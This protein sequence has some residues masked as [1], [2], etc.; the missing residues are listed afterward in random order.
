MPI[1]CCCPGMAFQT[2]VPI[3]VNVWQS[4]DEAVRVWCPGWHTVP[5]IRL[6][7]AQRTSL[8]SL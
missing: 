3:H 5:D 6:K 4:G 8:V 2:L 1:V 7:T